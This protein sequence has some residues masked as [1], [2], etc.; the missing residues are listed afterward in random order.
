M[1]KLGKIDFELN[2]AYK[3]VLYW[4][5]SY[6]NL[7]NSLNELSE[8]L[9]ISKTTAK[10]IVEQLAKEGF[11]LKKVYGKTWRITNNLSH[12]YNY[13]EKISFNLSLV[14]SAYF[15]K[16]KKELLN[17]IENPQSVI[18]FGSYRKGD[19]NENSDI[20]L[21]VEVLGEENLQ[22]IELGK[23]DLGYRKNV[24]V[25]LHVFSRSNIDINLFSNISN[26]IVI[27]GFLEVKP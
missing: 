9:K 6:P 7:E 22:I 12:E 15:K 11:L 26:G 13:S 4:F 21:A 23:I 19:D 25:N 1:K 8:S 3:K 20:D 16:I 17:L 5:F 27:E 2:E 10:Q 14:Y 24:P 18:L